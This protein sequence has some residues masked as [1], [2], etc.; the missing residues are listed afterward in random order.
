MRPNERPREIGRRNEELDVVEIPEFKQRAFRSLELAAPV[1]ARHKVRLAVEN[2]KDYRAGELA[3][4]M[5]RL[6]A[7]W[8]RYVAKR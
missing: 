8:N 3:D 4:V 7:T 2:H 5:K 6:L 1:M